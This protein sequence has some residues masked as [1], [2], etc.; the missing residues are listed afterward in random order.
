MFRSSTSTISKKRESVNIVSFTVISSIWWCHVVEMPL[1]GAKLL[2]MQFRRTFKTY[3]LTVVSQLCLQEWV[4][5]AL[6]GMMITSTAEIM[7]GGWRKRFS[8]SKGTT[9]CL[10][11][12]TLPPSPALCCFDPARF[13]TNMLIH[14]LSFGTL[15]LWVVL[16]KVLHL[17]T[18][19]STVDKTP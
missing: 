11:A 15:N 2:Y 18:F 9:Q 3:I 5:S 6:P 13:L 4:F 12:I 1:D 10:M 19:I 7:L 8:Q 14:S 17:F 16:S